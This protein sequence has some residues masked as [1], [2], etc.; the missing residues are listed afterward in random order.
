MHTSNLV[1]DVIIIGA[2]LHGSSA[3]LHL[4]K[5]NL[6]VILIDQGSGGRNSSKVNAG[7]L[8]QLN[9]LQPEIPLAVEAIKMWKNI[10]E[11]VGDDCGTAFDGQVCVAENSMDLKKLH[12]REI[13]LRELGYRH[14]ELIDAHE[15][16]K[17]I[18]SIS[19]RCIGGLICRS[20]GFGSPFRSTFAF[21]NTA[22]KLGVYFRRNSGVNRIR[23][24][25]SIWYVTTDSGENYQAPIVINSAG[26]WG[27]QIALMIGEE[28]P[29]SAEAPL[30]MVTAPIEFFLKPVVIGASRKFSFKQAPNGTVLIGGG[31]RGKLNRATGETRVD[32]D[33]LR[34]SAQT[35][36]DL[37]PHMKKVPIVRCWAGIEG[38]T[39]DRIPVLGES[40]IARGFYHSFGYS[41]HGYLLAPLTG[42]L[43][44]ELIVDNKPS[45]SIE[46]FS[47]ARFNPPVQ[48]PCDR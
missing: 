40:G 23:K 33:Q 6:K 2:G 10:K 27:D 17:L 28:L 32:F 45:L 42:R 11:L 8:R 26:A 4:A 21:Q 46:E 37:F 38:L 19:E 30:M 48:S 29:I 5:K 16:K 18:P 43:L 24:N 12:D 20:D 35:V 31:Y 15:L 3:A 25:D 1:F 36:A 13:R 41:S 47:A 7:G 34:L 39:P 14:E 22:E 44:S 9:R